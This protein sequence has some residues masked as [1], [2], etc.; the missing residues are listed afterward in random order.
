M[1]YIE[2]QLFHW[3]LTQNRQETKPLPLR[4]CWVDGRNHDLWAAWNSEGE[5]GWFFLF[6]ASRQ[7]AKLS[8]KVSIQEKDTESLISFCERCAKQ[9]HIWKGFG[10]HHFS[11][12]SSLDRLIPSM[13]QSAP[14]IY[15]G[16]VNDQN[17][18]LNR[19]LLVSLP[20][21]QLIYQVTAVGQSDMKN[22]DG[23][24]HPFEQ[25]CS[26]WLWTEFIGSKMLD[27]SEE[28]SH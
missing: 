6:Y 3:I 27:T 18:S 13:P 5:L 26:S 15:L 14:R 4:I 9:Y 23:F 21:D 20:S 16:T 25:L 12:W 2:H 7:V 24:Y 19:S 8:R 17:R 1:L 11:D 28:F 10:G 22:A